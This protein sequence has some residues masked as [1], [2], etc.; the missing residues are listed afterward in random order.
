MKRMVLIRVLKI[1]L[2]KLLKLLKKAKKRTFVRLYCN[3]ILQFV[4]HKI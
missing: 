1:A 3:C 2:V 4:N